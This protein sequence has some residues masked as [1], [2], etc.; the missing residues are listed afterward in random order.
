MTDISKFI[1]IIESYSSQYILLEAPFWG[2]NSPKKAGEQKRKDFINKM[3]ASWHEWLGMTGKEGTMADMANF[4]VSRVGFSSEDAAKILGINNT[5]MVSGSSSDFDDSK[6]TEEKPSE[7]TKPKEKE[8]PVNPSSQYKP[9]ANDHDYE[10]LEHNLKVAIDTSTKTDETYDNILKALDHFSSM[11]R[12]GIIPENKIKD[13]SNLV[14]D[15]FEVLNKSSHKISQSEEDAILYNI[16]KKTIKQN[17]QN[18]TG[19]PNTDQS[20]TQNES[21]LY[22]DL[23]SDTVLSKAEVS[24]VLN[25]A[26][27]F[28]FS[29]NIIGNKNYAYGNRSSESTSGEDYTSGDSYDKRSIPSVKNKVTGDL[30]SN[31]WGT[32]QKNGL[33]PDQD[34]SVLKDLSHKDFNTLSDADKKAMSGIGWAFL[35]SLR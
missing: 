27:K 29:N 13:I 32:V 12:S 16:Q 30:V 18:Q 3:E 22:E 11:G 4:L 26:A 21:R 8:E 6:N 28:A 5:P 15:A 7:E 35:R 1:Q 20:T 33:T 2:G 10:N 24:D 31:V 17:P 14:Q 25:D 34:F 9:L 19:K 23:L